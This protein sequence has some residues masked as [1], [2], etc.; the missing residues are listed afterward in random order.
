VLRISVSDHATSPE[1][2]DLS[3]KALIEAVAATKV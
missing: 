2:V 1:E 3:V